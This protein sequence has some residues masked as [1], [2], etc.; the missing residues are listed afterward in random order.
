[1]KLIDEQQRSTWKT[2]VTLI[3]CTLFLTACKNSNETNAGL[4]N[5]AWGIVGAYYC[6]ILPMPGGQVLCVF[7]GKDNDHNGA[8]QSGTSDVCIVDGDNDIA[9]I[10]C[11]RMCDLNNNCSKVQCP[12]KEQATEI[13]KRLKTK[14][15]SPA[16][17]SSKSPS[18]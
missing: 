11:K 4:C 17:D 18:T 5:G 8:Y 3:F 14:R 16:I 6:D 9:Y 15:L 2:V 7:F 12:S 10:D 1:M 13:E